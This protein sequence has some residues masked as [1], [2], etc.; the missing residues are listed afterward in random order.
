MILNPTMVAEEVVPVVGGTDGDVGL[1]VAVLALVGIG[2]GIAVVAVA[3]S[4]SVG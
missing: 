4:L 3:V 1:P 2:I